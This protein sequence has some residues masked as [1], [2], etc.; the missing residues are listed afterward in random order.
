VPSCGGAQCG[1]DGCGGSCGTCASGYAC[2]SSGTCVSTC[3]AETNSA[4]CARLGKNCGSVSDY[5]NCG[6]YRTAS[7]GSCS[8]SQTCSA[9]N[10]CTTT[11]SALLFKT[12]WQ[13]LTTISGHTVQFRCAGTVSSTA[14]GGTRCDISTQ[15]P[16]Q[17][18][19]DGTTYVLYPGC[20]GNRNTNCMTSID[21]TSA[22]YKDD[23]VNAGGRLLCDAM[24]WNL[25]STLADKNPGTTSRL[26]A[27]VQSSPSVT[28]TDTAVKN[29]GTYVECDP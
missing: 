14:A 6:T 10:V 9:S 21:P 29:Y 4:F 13:T 19:I 5:D 20:D 23:E 26:V 24:G 7:C 11:T 28:G 1:P 8:G 12:T 22:V 16:V 2:N 15:D 18:S 27:V 25:T 3:T 17:L